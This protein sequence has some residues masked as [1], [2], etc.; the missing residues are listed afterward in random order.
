[1]Q[2]DAKDTYI[3]LNKHQKQSLSQ[4][5]NISDLNK[6]NFISE[7]EEDII[8]NV[9]ENDEWQFCGHSGI[10]ATLMRDF[11][12]IW[13]IINNR[14]AMFDNLYVIGHSLGGGLAILF[15]LESIINKYISSNKSIKIIT[16]G[17]P[18]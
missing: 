13:K 9:I 1:M 17:S 8:E 16:F 5:L 4:Q 7:K 11:H 10:Y 15:G 6:I 12:R 18:L 14:I 2:R 3:K